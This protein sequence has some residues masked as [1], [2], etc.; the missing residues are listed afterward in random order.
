MEIDMVGQIY[1]IPC[2]LCF[3]VSQETVGDRFKLTLQILQALLLFRFSL[4]LS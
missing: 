1:I 2:L 4:S 3:N